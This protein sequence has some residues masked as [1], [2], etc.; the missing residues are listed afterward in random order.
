MHTVS[1]SEDRTTEQ[2]QVVLD[3]VYKKFRQGGMTQ[4]NCDR[5]LTFLR[6]GATDPAASKGTLEWPLFS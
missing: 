6:K 3:P 2:L 1:S 4:A 5:L